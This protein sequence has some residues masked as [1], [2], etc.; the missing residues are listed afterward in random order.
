MLEPFIEFHF[1][2]NCNCCVF[3]AFEGLTNISARKTGIYLILIES[4]IGSDLSRE[5]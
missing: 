5:Y 1:R 3:Q 4:P 2:K